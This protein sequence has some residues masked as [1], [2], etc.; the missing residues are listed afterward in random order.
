MLISSIPI[1]KKA[2]FI[3]LLVP[4]ITGI[5]FQWYL[6]IS[7]WVAWVAFALALVISIT[8]YFPRDYLRYRLTMINGTAVIVLFFSLG[9]LL[10]K[11]KD[12]RNDEKW[13][14]KNYKAGDAIKI[15]LR[16]PLIE[17]T[18]SQKAVASVADLVRSNGI[19]STRGRIV[20]Y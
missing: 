15:I 16:E 10:T 1:W 5:I 11:F 8:G 20:V 17:K 18:H 9:C 3:R 4:L 6:Q 14:G 12:I 19:I 13:F 2:P 7:E